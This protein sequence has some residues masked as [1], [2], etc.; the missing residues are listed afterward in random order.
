MPGVGSGG[1]A[2]G[3]LMWGLR[4]DLCDMGGTKFRINEVTG[5]VWEYGGGESEAGHK[6]RARV[7]NQENFPKSGTQGDSYRH[8]KSAR[9]RYT[10]WEGLA[11]GD[12]GVGGNVA[13]DS[14]CWKPWSGGF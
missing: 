5:R 6:G 10:Q 4:E 1:R 3:G 11:E 14:L 2:G 9:A 8:H 12:E 13:V 7:E